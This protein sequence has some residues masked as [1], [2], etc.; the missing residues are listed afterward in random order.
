MLAEIADSSLLTSILDSRA[1]LNCSITA[2]SARL[3]SV[4]SRVTFAKPVSS[5]VSSRIAVRMTLAQ[6]RE[7]SLRTRQ[8]SSSTRPRSRGQAQQFGGPAALRIF[9]REEAREMQA[10]DLIGR[11]AA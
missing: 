7:P 1:V 8:P 11:V 9:L 6:K 4:K 10:E 5:P 2:S 3:R